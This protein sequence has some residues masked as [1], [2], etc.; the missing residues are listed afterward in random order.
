MTRREAYDARRKAARV[1]LK[2]DLLRTL[3]AHE[4]R[5]EPPDIASLAQD[6]GVTANTIHVLR[7]ELASEGLVADPQVR[8][9][10]RTDETRVANLAERV[11][12]VREAQ[13]AKWSQGDATSLSNKELRKVLP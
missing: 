12:R 6:F 13:V 11:A 2:A 9:I 3:Q 10:E 1:A 4:A 5:G 8:R 7:R